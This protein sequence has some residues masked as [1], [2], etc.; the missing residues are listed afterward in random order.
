M[1]DHVWIAN[2]QEWT[3]ISVAD[4]GRDG[5]EPG[6]LIYDGAQRIKWGTPDEATH[7]AI[8]VEQYVRIF[9]EL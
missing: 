2:G 6:V 8:P 5:H 7:V 4:L 3:A 1:P 9:G